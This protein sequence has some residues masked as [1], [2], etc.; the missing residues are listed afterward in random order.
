MANL[1]GKQNLAYGPNSQFS[2]FYQITHRST[3]AIPLIN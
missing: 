3:S 1:L 2:R